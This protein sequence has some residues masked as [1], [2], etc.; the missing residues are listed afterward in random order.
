[1]RE[2]TKL[3]HA[4]RCRLLQAVYATPDGRSVIETILN[5]CDVHKSPW[6]S[7]KPFDTAHHSG[8]QWVGL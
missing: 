5:L 7:E 6:R 2:P 1:M 4:D 8:R 3:D